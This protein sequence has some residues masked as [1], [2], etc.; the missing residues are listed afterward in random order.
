MQNQKGIIFLKFLSAPH[1]SALISVRIVSGSTIILR[2]KYLVQ[3]LTK[4]ARAILS[5]LCCALA[6]SVLGFHTNKP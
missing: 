3:L 4:I 5:F 6:H 2:V 1:P